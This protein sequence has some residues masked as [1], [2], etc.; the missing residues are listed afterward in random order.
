[1]ADFSADNW[2]RLASAAGK[3][4]L[5]WGSIHGA[6]FGIFW[7]SSGMSQEQAEDIYFSIRSDSLQREV[8]LKSAGHFLADHD[9]IRSELKSIFRRI[10]NLASH[11]NSVVHTIWQKMDWQREGGPPRQHVWISS[12]HPQRKSSYNFDLTNQFVA[13]FDKA[14]SDLWAISS[15]LKAMNAQILEILI[16]RLKERRAKDQ[17]QKDQ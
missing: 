16:E 4:T 3:V 15:E 12:P 7:M 13:K 6:V 11:R 1:M 14:E 10:D 17:Q 5:A 2:E 9:Q 8:T